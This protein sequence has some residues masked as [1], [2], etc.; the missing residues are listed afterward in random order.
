MTFGLEVDVD[1][2]VWNTVKVISDVVCGMI[3]VVYVM[4]IRMS[5]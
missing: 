2:V 5:L 3:R 1:N 4:T